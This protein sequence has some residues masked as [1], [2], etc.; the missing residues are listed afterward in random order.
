M[1]T[2]L[3]D[4]QRRFSEAR[5]AVDRGETVTVRSGD[6]VYLFMRRPDY[7]GNPFADLEHL[8]GTAS[9]KSTKASPSDKIRA[10]LRKSVSR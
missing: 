6:A 3:T 2:T 9:L 8:F 5:S 1:E 10:R 7:P 4:F